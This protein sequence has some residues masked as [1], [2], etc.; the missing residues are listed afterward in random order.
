MAPALLI[1]FIGQLCELD[2]QGLNG[3]LWDPDRFSAEVL[4]VGIPRPMELDVANDG[5]IY[6]I[7]LQGSLKR[8]DP[9]SKT[10]QLIGSL[11]V[12]DGQENGLI[13]LAL[14]PDFE[15]N[16]RLYLQYSPSDF[17]GQHISRFS[18]DADGN[19]DMASEELILKFDEQRDECCHHAGSL[20]FGPNG[21]L[22][23]ATG[24]NTH[25]GG[26]S[27]GYAPIDE[28]EGRHAYDAQDSAGNTM[29]LRGKILRIR[30]SEGGGYTIPEGNLFPAG[31]P[32][33]GRPEIYVMGCRNPWRMQVDQATGYVY[34]GEV[35]PDAGGEGP[36]GPR[37]YDEVNQARQAGNFGWPFF[38]GA[39]F[40]YADFDYETKEVGPLYDATRP[41]NRSPTNTGSRFLP[42][43][44]P[45]WI[46]YPYAQSKE[47]PIVG[48]GGRT[49]CAGPVFHYNA[50]SNSPTQFPKSLDG[51]MLFFDWQRPLFM[52]A[53]LDENSELE[54]IIPFPSPI[55]LRRPVD[56]VFG[57]E[58]SLYVLDY[59]ETW[60]VNEDAK[61]VRI[62]Y[63]S[64]NRP[65]KAALNATPT[66]GA[67]PLTVSLDASKSTDTDPD[68]VLTYHWTLTP[69]IGKNFEGATGVLEL[70]EEGEYQITLEVR[71]QAGAKDLA[72]ERVVVGNT[73]PQITILAPGVDGNLIDIS[74]STPIE[75]VV[76]DVED[77]S[78]NDNPAFFENRVF[79]RSTILQ[80]ALPDQ[81]ETIFNTGHQSGSVGLSRIQSL[82]CLNCHAIDK[83]VVGPAF[84]E[85]AERYK[86]DKEALDRAAL[87]VVKGSTGVWGELPML[88]H[89]ALTMEQAKEMVTWIL[90]REGRE[91][92]QDWR[93]G[94]KFELSAKKAEGAVEQIASGLIAIEARYNDLGSPTAPTLSGQNLTIWR[95]SW[96]Q[97]EAF[98]RKQGTQ[99]LSS[100]SAVQGKFI[101]DIQNDNY[102]VFNQLNWGGRRKLVASVASPDSGGRVE[103]RKNRQDGP[104]LGVIEF[105]STGGWEDWKEVSTK[106]QCVSEPVDLFVIFKHPS[107]SSGGGFMNM[108]WIRFE[109]GN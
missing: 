88:P 89:E 95:S 72:Y 8:W 11:D 53:K 99:I 16:N 71:D 86:E 50:D 29:D 51:S 25:P 97:G 45:A 102:L 14:D 47:F 34:W 79:S 98:N 70:D 32:I 81:P 30:P 96:I 92:A 93:P 17:V 63:Y 69:D 6:F 2:A 80:G 7:E 38:V 100:K 77:G 41:E 54:E 76:E 60:G 67:A 35:G 58:G 31:G 105:K 87:R 33:Q 9:K 55:K 49:A 37:G 39:N 21:L 59:G 42:P 52:V 27:G 19:L 48:S 103:F 1:T 74:G 28:R 46:Y 23:I 20:E 66:S 101:G 91:G 65:P 57:P 44:Q 85:I 56:M 13:G 3:S 84:N 106:I 83:R 73:V 90:D 36:R 82:D 15:S 18:L 24:D 109:D 22:Y 43:A 61:L 75:I 5:S 4:D 107:G 12:Y 40:A 64:G 26:D 10:S 68:D 78:S 108:D 104:V 94:L 62:D